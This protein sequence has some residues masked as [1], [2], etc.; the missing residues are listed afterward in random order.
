MA[1][2]PDFKDN[3]REEI[4]LEKNS[5]KNVR[6]LKRIIDQ[7]IY[8]NAYTIVRAK[9]FNQRLK[10]YFH[11]SKVMEFT[12]F[13]SGQKIA[14]VAIWEFEDLRTDISHLLQELKSRDFYI[15]L[16][17]NG[18]INASSIPNTVA[19]YIERFNYG[20][21]FGCYKDG[22][23]YLRKGK[24]LENAEKLL[25]LNDS[26]YY[27]QDFIGNGLDLILKSDLDAV[28][29]T[30]NF[31]YTHHLGS[32]SILFSKKVLNSHKFIAFWVK[33]RKSNIRTK[34]IRYGELK[35]SEEV[36]KSIPPQK[37]GAIWGVS[38]ISTSVEK[39]EQLH[40]ALLLVN[41]GLISTW[42]K[43][44]WQFI[45]K[46]LL[47]ERLVFPFDM[48]KR[49]DS[50]IQH[51]NSGKVNDLHFEYVDNY[52]DVLR[53]LSKFASGTRSAELENEVFIR[54]KGFWV[55]V[56]SSGS[57]IHQ[58]N[59]LLVSFGCP[60]VKLDLIYRG[61]FKYEDAER[62]F[63]QISNQVDKDLIRNILYSR[64]YGGDVLHGWKRAAFN[65]GLI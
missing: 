4:E 9:D 49:G 25:I 3:Q 12:E 35:L 14:L 45:S 40:S 5:K 37:F 16:V 43:L 51:T 48:S 31:D 22:I 44:S 46:S 20:M 57:G 29:F 33:F 13:R 15:V 28:G 53:I 61:A 64:A 42:K 17:N 24:K 32:F 18:T 1:I 55:G 6:T 56:V 50:I 7:L 38:K 47:E 21:D 39:P 30:E 41:R 54:A 27:L 58:N 23:Q 11:K 10:S 34:N 63:M 59:N 26:V 60:L 62:M 52:D 36:R 2:D 8:P 65:R 19:V